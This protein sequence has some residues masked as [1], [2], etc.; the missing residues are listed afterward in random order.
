MVARVC[1]TGEGEE[2][3]SE[4]G[5]GAAPEEEEAG[6]QA[7]SQAGEKTGVVGQARCQEAGSPEAGR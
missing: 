5:Q 3:R 7:R 2:A 6:S 1:C 4:A